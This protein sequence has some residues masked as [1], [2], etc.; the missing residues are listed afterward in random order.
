MEL[1]DGERVEELVR[2]QKERTLWQSLDAVVVGQ[3]LGDGV[4]LAGAENGGGFDE[5]QFGSLDKARDGARGAERIGHERSAT[6]AKFSQEEGRGAPSVDPALGKK[7][8]QHLAEHL[9]DL[10]GGYEIALDPQW[11]TGGVIAVVRVEERL[12]HVVGDGDWPVPRDAGEERLGQCRHGRRSAQI[13][14][15]RPPMIIG[16][17]RSC[18]IERPKSPIKRTRPAGLS[19]VMNCASATR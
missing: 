16:V 7:Q 19:G 11:I 2:D 1:S 12:V 8:A 4:D 3:G 17:E 6:R 10:G 9:A 18:P 15:P 13:I 14:R 5:V